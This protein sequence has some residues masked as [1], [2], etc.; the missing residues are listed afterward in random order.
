[1]PKQ[2]LCAAALM[3][4]VISS[5]F[6][7]LA[8]VK[9]FSHLSHHASRRM[10][11]NLPYGSLSA[12]DAMG[13]PN[14]RD[15]LP[16]VRRVSR[17]DVDRLSRG[18]AAKVKGYGSRAVPHRL[19]EAESQ[20][21]ERARIRG[22]LQVAGT[23]RRR[24]RK[25]SPLCNLH[26]QW[27][28]ALGRPQVVL[29]K[30]VG[31]VDAGEPVRDEL[32][33]DLSPL[34]LRGAYLDPAEVEALENGYREI[35]QSAAIQNNMVFVPENAEDQEDFDDNDAKILADA[36]DW[37]T[38]PI[39]KLPMV[40]VGELEGERSN[41]KRMAK[42]LAELWTIPEKTPRAASSML[43]KKGGG[44]TKMKTLSRHR[45]N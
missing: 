44:K 42:Q 38:L 6:L 15:V 17:D 19:N 32:V 43:H 37:A 41:A 34:R 16:K 11:W 35:L 4:L 45:I 27:C 28:D 40:R 36:S 24:E 14:L 12:N 9:A 2:T 23:G 3:M 25:G 5:P 31:S 29:F 33:V 10:S 1:M 21:W 22:Y 18:L 30:V 20:E 39:W 13:L 8:P 26:R 7:R